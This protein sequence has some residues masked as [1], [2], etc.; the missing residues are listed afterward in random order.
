MA[1]M[2]NSKTVTTIFMVV[3]VLALV[4]LAFSVDRNNSSRDAD[5]PARDVLPGLAENLL[6]L[7]RITDLPSNHIHVVHIQRA[8]GEQL[9]VAKSS[10]TDANFALPE[11]APDDL[12]P[13]SDILYGNSVLLDSQSSA[14]DFIVTGYRLDELIG[15][16]LYSSF[17]GL[18]IEQTVYL[19]GEDVWMK[20]SATY[21]ALLAEQFRAG[22]NEQKLLATARVID[23]A[24]R[25]N[26]R[27]Y[28]APQKAN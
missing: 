15:R 22:P 11:D 14:E 28:K 10:L 13:F 9:I 3:T 17:D 2:E 1:T 7:Q 19:S 5:L 24:N 8:T 26:G 20:I 6:S 21:N 23:I 12:T 25:L 4:A 27:V 18:V 16:L